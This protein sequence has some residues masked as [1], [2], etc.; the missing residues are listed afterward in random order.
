MG[1]SRTMADAYNA[2]LEY[3]KTLLATDPRFQCHVRILHEEGTSYYFKYAFIMEWTHPDAA[4][5]RP[6]WGYDYVLVF[7]EHQRFHVFAKDE[8]LEATQ[9]RVVKKRERLN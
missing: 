2:A 8:L 3:D 5:P 9:L 4:N 1:M 6:G 7:T